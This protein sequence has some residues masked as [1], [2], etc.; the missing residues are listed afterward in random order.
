MLSRVALRAIQ[1][2]ALR[3]SLAT[4]GIASSTVWT[5]SMARHNRP[6]NNPNSNNNNKNGNNSKPQDPIK[7]AAPGVAFT[8]SHSGARGG[9]K[10]ARIDLSKGANGFVQGIPPKRNDFLR[11]EGADVKT[12]NSTPRKEEESTFSEEQPDFKASSPT[13][14][15]VPE[16]EVDAAQAEAQAEAQRRALPDLR[17]G[18]PSTLEY[19]A[20]GAPMNITESQDP[21][22]Q[23]GRGKGE[24]PA[25]A[26]I[27]SSDK[28]RARAANIMYALFAGSAFTGVLYLGRNWDDEDEERLHPD[29]PSG[30]AL[31]LMWNRAKARLGDQLNYY[32]EPAFQKLLPPQDPAFERPYTLVLSL[33]DMLLHSEWTR[34][35][36]WRMAKRPGVDYFLRYLCNYYEIVIFTSQPSQMAEP[37]I[38]KLDPF[39]IAQ[40]PLYREATYYENGE[41]VKVWNPLQ[42]L[43]YK[44]TNI[45][46]I[47]RT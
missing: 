24:L 15:E 8:P 31:G 18:I 3:T 6:N 38:R 40:W 45:D 41:Y 29:A 36:G 35:H 25:S 19:E 20:S 34:E 26:Y 7:P 17:Y 22:S 27:S 47:C 2:P 1:T 13:E 5:R 46:R 14:N 44:K 37:I 11:S 43:A 21:Q 16:T 4:F 33:E 42:I 9:D 30:W 39:R 12:S 10:S 28:K 23:G 32:N